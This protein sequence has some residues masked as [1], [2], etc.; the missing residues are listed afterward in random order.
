MTITSVQQALE[1]LRLQREY[2]SRQSALIDD[3]RSRDASQRVRNRMAGAKSVDSTESAAKPL[4]KDSCSI[5]LGGR[6][7]SGD[8]FQ[9]LDDCD[10]LLQFLNQRAR[11][12][13]KI[14]SLPGPAAVARAA[15]AQIGTRAASGT[16]DSDQND[17]STSAAEN[18]ET[19]RMTAKSDTVII[20]E[21]RVHNDALRAH[22]LDLLNEAE[23]YQRQEDYTRREMD[24]L[25]GDNRRLKERL[26]RL[27]NNAPG[28]SGSPLATTSD[29]FYS[30]PVGMAL[31]LDNLPSLELPPLEVP[32]F[33]F[34]TLK[35][36]GDWDEEEGPRGSS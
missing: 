16:A 4:D 13:G 12:S 2:H 11:T 24:Y 26:H 30:F 1:S 21:L 8:V 9:T 29:T 17:E 36:N 15:G 33:D 5:G 14:I 35:P 27:E 18:V 28:A 3:R 22:I 7:S 31:N 25:R 34:N 20:E 6:Q 23:E 19:K 10:S 32:K